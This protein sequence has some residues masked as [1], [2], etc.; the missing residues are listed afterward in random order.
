MRFAAL[1][2][3]ALPALVL[4]EPI[5]APT[6]APELDK[7]DIFGDIASG[8]SSAFGQVTA[9]AGEVVTFATSVGGQGISVISVGGG[10]VYTLATNGA[11]QVTSIGGSVY[12][13][14]TDGFGSF[15]SSAGSAFSSAT[16][17][18][19]AAGTTVS[20]ISTTLVMSLAGTVAG[21]VMGAAFIF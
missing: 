14:A 6:A 11:G 8:A 21:V 3:L 19:N 7:R 13:V 10:S 4:A 17:S 20:P 16:Q 9:A 15:T 1:A 12:T 5:P 2:V 18:R